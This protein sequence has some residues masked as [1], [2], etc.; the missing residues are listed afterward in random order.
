MYV[1]AFFILLASLCA[2]RGLLVLCGRDT[3]KVACLRISCGT[4]R[5]RDIPLVL[6]VVSFHGTACL[7]F[8]GEVVQMMEQSDLSGRD[9]AVDTL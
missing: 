7:L 6:A 3:T 8:V 9:A 2:G 5:T 4:L 1:L